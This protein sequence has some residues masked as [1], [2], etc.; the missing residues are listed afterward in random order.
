M[1]GTVGHMSTDL[2]IEHYGVGS[3][4]AQRLRAMAEACG[5][6]LQK[7]NIVKDFAKDLNR[8][9]C[10][11]PDRWLQEAVFAV[12]IGGSAGPVDDDGH[13]QCAD[14]T[15][16]RRRVMCRPCHMPPRA[17]AWRAC[18]ACSPGERRCYWPHAVERSFSR[19]STR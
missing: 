6:G 16:A 11:L 14:R 13:R 19:R 5:R 10:Y 4:T 2:L 3:D 18:C 12:G 15:T 1:A 9:M 8:G 7:T 17:I